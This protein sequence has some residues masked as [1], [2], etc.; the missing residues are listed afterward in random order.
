MAQELTQRIAGLWTFPS[1]LTGAPEGS[2][3]IADN[4]VIDRDNDAEPRRGFDYLT[5]AGIQSS[6]RSGR[7]CR[8]R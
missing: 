8:D 1:D 3:A 5:H 4:I 2:L 7:T 6:F